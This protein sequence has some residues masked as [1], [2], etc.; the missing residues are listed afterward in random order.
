MQSPFVLEL[1]VH[2][3]REAIL[4]QL[5]HLG[6]LVQSVQQG[7]VDHLEHPVRPELLVVL[8]RPVPKVQ[9]VLQELLVFRE[10]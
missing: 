1:Q 9:V 7:L 4:E 6:T 5:V 3:D 8:V 10:E 2:L